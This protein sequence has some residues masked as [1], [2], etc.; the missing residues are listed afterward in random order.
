M[1]RPA[2]PWPPVRFRPPPPILGCFHHRVFRCNLF[3]D[4]PWV[5]DRCRW[6]CDDRGS[7]VIPGGDHLLQGGMTMRKILLTGVA[8]IGIAVVGWV[9]PGSLQA[10][11]AVTIDNDDIGGVRTR[12]QRAAIRVSGVSGK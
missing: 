1:Q 8:A 4:A 11:Q 3:A 5:I 12:P 10:Q 9:A 2:K 6:S 7:H